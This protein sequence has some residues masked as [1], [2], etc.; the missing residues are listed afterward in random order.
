[1]IIPT[2]TPNKGDGSP[3]KPLRIKTALMAKQ[4]AVPTPSS[5]FRQVTLMGSSSWDTGGTCSLGSAIGHQ[6]HTR[7]HQDNTYDNRQTQD[8]PE[9][10]QADG[11]GEKRRGADKRAGAGSAD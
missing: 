3:S 1:M 7:D 8:F 5:E 9:E 6:V 4:M 10:H 11:E 2:E